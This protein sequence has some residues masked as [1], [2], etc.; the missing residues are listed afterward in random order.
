MPVRYDLENHI[1]T[2]TIDR[3]D[4]F[5]SIDLETWTAF[6]EATERLEGDA[7]AWTGI[8]TGAG[9]RAFSAGADLRSTIPRL[10][11]DPDRNPYPEPPTIMRGQTITKPLIAAVNGLALGGGLE[12][13]LACDLRVAA[14]KARFGAPEVTLGLIPGWGGT[15]R[16]PRQLPW[17]V[18]ARILLSGQ[19]LTAQE[20]FQVGLVN[21][22][23]PGAEVMAEA[24][25]WAETLLKCGPLALR[26]AKRAMLEGYHLPLEEG[27]AVEQ[28]LFN[29]LAYTEDV[30]EGLAA[31]SE[32]R[33]P[34]FKAK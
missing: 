10:M 29:S 30:R 2:I 17:A 13:V 15:Q 11:D 18:A 12:I 7:E 5:N 14:E 19:P 4:A 34:Q 31:F 9:N 27:L 26:A 32:K 22:V 8:I 21:A 33:P 24:R 23:V 3:P 28:R 6:S 20:A 16:L 1:A 25:R